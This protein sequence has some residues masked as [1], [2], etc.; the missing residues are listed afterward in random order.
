MMIAT[1]RQG[2]EPRRPGFLQPAGR[3][4]LLLANRDGTGFYETGEAVGGTEPGSPVEVAASAAPDA[5][6]RRRT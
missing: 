6:C 1:S 5:A 2:A 3:H 4:G